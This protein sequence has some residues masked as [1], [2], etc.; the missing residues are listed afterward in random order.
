MKSAST[1]RRYL[2]ARPLIPGANQLHP[3]VNANGSAS[4][5]VS[6]DQPVPHGAGAL[7]ISVCVEED[8]AGLS[9][10]VRTSE[11]ACHLETSRSGF[12]LGAAAGDFGLSLGLCLTCI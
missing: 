5:L 3:N 11:S 1:T 4:S 9:G 12:H 7:S 10:P 6:V 8:R 2:G